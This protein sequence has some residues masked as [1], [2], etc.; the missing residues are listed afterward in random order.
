MTKVSKLERLRGESACLVQIYGKQLGRRWELRGRTLSI[1][2]E[3]GNDLVIESDAVSRRH[4]RVDVGEDD[5]TI[6]DLGSTNGTYVNETPAKATPL[7]HGDLVKIGDTIFKYLAEGNLESAYHEEIYRLTIVDGL[8]EIHNKRYMLEYLDR[9]LSRCLR[10]GRPLALV[11]FDL[12]HFKK[13]NDTFGHFAGDTV[14]RA[15]SAVVRDRIRREEL[16]A[17][18]GGEEFAIV[19]PETPRDAALLFAEKVRLLVVENPVAF[20]A[21]QIPV[22]VSLGVGTISPT[23]KTVPDLIEAA[24]KNL[25]KAKNQGRNRVVG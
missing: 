4:A 10:Y 19:L 1:G 22:T 3:E 25:Y 9:E 16:F 23:V 6:S 5:V 17:R 2:R 8:T 13:V 18:Y 20:E 14:L 11:M 24:D 7:N 21:Q 12:D 15:V